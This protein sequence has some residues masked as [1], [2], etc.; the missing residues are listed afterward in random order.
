VYNKPNGCS[1]SGALVPGPDHQQQQQQQIGNENAIL[2]RHTTL[3]EK[4]TGVRA[5]V[6]E[7]K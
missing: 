6:L 1:A 7:T 2:F 3:S 5:S 4:E